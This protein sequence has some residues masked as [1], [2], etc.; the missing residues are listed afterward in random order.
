MHRCTSSDHHPLTDLSALVGSLGWLRSVA[1]RQASQPWKPILCGPSRE[2]V[3][4][5]L[6]RFRRE[7]NAALRAITETCPAGILLAAL[8]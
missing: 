8:H 2:A 1:R 4:V 6:N 7:W 3:S 5:H